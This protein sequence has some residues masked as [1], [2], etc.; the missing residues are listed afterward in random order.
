MVDVLVPV[1]EVYVNGVDVHFFQIE[2][3]PCLALDLPTVELHQLL[4]A[5]VGVEQ[6][7]PFLGV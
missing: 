7:S 2:L 4:L 5:V 6:L 1:S 3:F